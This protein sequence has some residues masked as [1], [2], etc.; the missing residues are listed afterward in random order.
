MKT[1]EA[2]G[3]AVANALDDPDNNVS[4]VLS[5]LTGVFVR[6]CVELVRRNGADPEKQITLNGGDSRDITIHPKKGGES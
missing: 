1:L 4:D 6:L 3:D 2:L 5:V